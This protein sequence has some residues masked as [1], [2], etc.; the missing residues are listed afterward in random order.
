MLS[1]IG[2]GIALLLLRY[3]QHPGNEVVVIVDMNPQQEA[4]VPQTEEP[5]EPPPTISIDQTVP[6]MLDIQP[7]PILDNQ[8]PLTCSTCDLSYDCT[9]LFDFQFYTAHYPEIGAKN[10]T[11]ALEHWTEHGMA[12]GRRQHAGPKIFKV[13]LMTKNDWPLLKSWVLHHS[14]VFG[15]ENL[16]IV[17]AST[18]E[19]VVAFLQEASIRL[20]VHVLH[21]TANLNSVGDEINQLMA[22]L[23]PT[24]DFMTKL[25]T[26]EFIIL[27]NR[28]KNDFQV[29]G[30]MAYIDTMH[31]TGAR[32]RVGYSLEGGIPPKDCTIDDDPSLEIGFATGGD[33]SL[34]FPYRKAMFPGFSFNYTDLGNHDG[35]MKDRFESLPDITP[36][37][38]VVHFRNQCYATY[39]A[40]TYRAVMSHGYVNS[41]DSA[42]EM[43]GK[44][45]TLS[46]GPGKR[47]CEIPS[48]HKVLKYLDHLWDEEGDR[49]KYYANGPH[50]S[51]TF[52][53]LRDELMYLKARYD[54]ESQPP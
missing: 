26:D 3:L 49:D 18:R 5:A 40:N 22:T 15:G 4:T 14:H 6:P 10:A 9:P 39:I 52:T 27:Y 30:V 44:L 13:I 54:S 41:T 29:D 19:E 11:E 20:G 2:L 24:C 38:A 37:L 32:Y 36:D 45:E 31:V 34:P 12:Q 51:R 42:Q 1:L 46:G 47:D 33:T 16:Y 28:E 17:D 48:C 7:P 23:G 53:E 8:T 21:S 50:S 43:I 25:D 35:F